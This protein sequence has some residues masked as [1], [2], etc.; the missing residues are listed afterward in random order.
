[1][2]RYHWLETL[3]TAHYPTLLRLAQNR[4]RAMIG[5]TSEA[6]DVVQDVFVLA[7]E[8]DISNLDNPLPWLMKATVNMCRKRL[9]RKLR[10]AEKEQ[11]IIRR[12]LDS[13]PDRSVYAVERQASATDALELLMTYEQALSKEDW[14]I[15][16]QFCLQGVP[17]EEISA[18]T[19]IPINT[20]RVRICRIRKKF[21]KIDPDV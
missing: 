3:H 12:K 5:S 19:G 2:S 11:R 8:K 16:R 10:E 18:Q 13:S 6:E 7:A 20:L 9:D 17:I 14:D 1:M 15:M 4:L 21:E